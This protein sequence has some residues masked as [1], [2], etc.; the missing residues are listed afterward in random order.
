VQPAVASF[1]KM[2]ISES[3]GN[4]STGSTSRKIGVRKL[5]I[6]ICPSAYVRLRRMRALSHYAGTP[7]RLNFASSTS[8]KSSNGNSPRTLSRSRLVLIKYYS[9]NMGTITVSVVPVRLLLALSFA[10]TWSPVTAREE[11][12]SLATRFVDSVLILKLLSWDQRNNFEEFMLPVWGRC[13]I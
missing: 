11:I 5:S 8:I 4:A 12:R 3:G 13:V 7:G 6:R 2:A 10:E 1:R 9:L